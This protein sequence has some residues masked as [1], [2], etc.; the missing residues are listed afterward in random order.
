MS[1]D[2]LMKVDIPYPYPQFTDTEFFLTDSNGL[3]ISDIYY[4]LSDDR[5]RVI[6]KSNASSLGLTKNSDIR[7]TFCHNHNKYH[8]YKFE[9]HVICKSGVIQYNLESPFKKIVDIKSRYRVFYNRHAIDLERK[10]YTIDNYNGKIG[11]HQF[12]HV[13][14]G[15]T[16]DIVTFYTGS[17]KNQVVSNLPMSGYI[18]LKRNEIDRNYNNNLMA[19]FVNGKLIPRNKIVHMSNNIYKISEDI[20]TRY[21]LDVRNMS[22]RVNSIAPFYQKNNLT[23]DTPMQNSIYD[24]PCSLEIVTN[25]HNRH[26]LDIDF[27]PVMIDPSLLPNK[28][29]YFITLMHHGY[30][31][32]DDYVNTSL[33][34]N[35]K[36]YRDD[37]AE[38]NEPVKIVTLLRYR[39]HNREEERI[40]TSYTPLLM[41]TIN[42]VHETSK[43]IPLYSIRIES[44]VKGD[45]SNADKHLD[46]V[47]CRFQIESPVKEDSKPVYYELTS[48]YFEKDEYIGVFEWV[49][50][51]DINGT[52]DIL[53]R[54]PVYLI[55]KNKQ[56]IYNNIDKLIAA[57]ID[58]EDEEGE[59]K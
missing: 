30:V 6:F 44:V 20:N 47:L 33:K 45:F 42:E 4:D 26:S 49:V 40:Q 28:E 39:S 34:Y 38:Q 18:Y 8:I 21:N 11:L 1:N 31:L 35:L 32:E 13:K 19:I 9:Q 56:E 16:L 46:G 12:T 29:N 25:K 14:D 15:D 37:Y 54:K 2:N 59:N 22:P 57:K 52:G 55:P 41:G 24:F 23:I 53:Y 36:F 50:S 58:K 43:D 17:D 48:D 27:N 5:K 10:D 7:F 3:F 51:T